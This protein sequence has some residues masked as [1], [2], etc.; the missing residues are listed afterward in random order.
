V[1]PLLQ[2]SIKYLYIHLYSSKDTNNFIDYEKK[3]EGMHIFEDTS[4]LAI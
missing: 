4:G 2:I 3:I 1:E